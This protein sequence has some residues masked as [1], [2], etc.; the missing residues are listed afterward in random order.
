MKMVKSQYV[1]GFYD[2]LLKRGICTL[3]EVLIHMKTTK[4]VDEYVQCV[5]P[6]RYPDGVDLCIY[7]GER[8]EFHMRRFQTCNEMNKPFSY[9][10]IIVDRIEMT[11]T[12]RFGMRYSYKDRCDFILKDRN[13]SVRMIIN[14]CVLSILEDMRLDKIINMNETK[15]VSISL[16]PY[17]KGRKGS[18][19]MV[20]EIHLHH[21][22]FNIYK[23]KYDIPYESK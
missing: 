9:N 13:V 17:S 14:L 12:D 19:R 11:T 22:G 4:M 21:T 2:V 1:Y 15:M 20:M 6:Y 10:R 8:W 7:F 3:H 5:Y 23:L 18:V 16:S